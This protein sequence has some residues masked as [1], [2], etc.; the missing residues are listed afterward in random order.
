[1][2]FLKKIGQRIQSRRD[3]RFRRRIERM[4]KNQKVIT[5]GENAI[6]VGVE[7]QKDEYG[8]IC[9]SGLRQ[10]ESSDQER[11]PTET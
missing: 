4:L 6:P 5:P 1:M 2:F 3:E 7:E 10:I 8:R 9:H 11:L